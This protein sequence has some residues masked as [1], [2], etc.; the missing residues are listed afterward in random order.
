MQSDE[1]GSTGEAMKLTKATKV[2]KKVWCDGCD[3]TG[4]MEGWN[5][6]DGSSCPKC[7]GKAILEKR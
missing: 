6:R 4:L 3:G 1:I 5:H 2:A 7:K